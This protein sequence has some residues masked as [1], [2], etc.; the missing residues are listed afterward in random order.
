M[1]GRWQ[2]DP[3]FFSWLSFL[4]R[5]DISEGNNR[6]SWYTNSIPPLPVAGI[7]VFEKTTFKT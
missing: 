5:S 1:D 6:S 4:S 7:V 3:H 2:I